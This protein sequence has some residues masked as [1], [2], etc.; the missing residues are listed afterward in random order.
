MNLSESS[1]VN[2]KNDEKEFGI[3]LSV[4]ISDG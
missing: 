3:T 4:E 2:E 1:I